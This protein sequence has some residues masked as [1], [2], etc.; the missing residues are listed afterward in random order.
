MGGQQSVP[1]EEQ[2]FNM[3]FTARQLNKLSQKHEKDAAKERKKIKAAIDKGNK[4]GAQIY[5]ENTIRKKN[6]ALQMLQLSSRI[7]GV[8]SK[9]K[10]IQAQ[11]GVARSMGAISQQ[12][13]VA[14]Q[15]M[16]TMAIAQNMDEFERQ[17]N[18][19]D[20]QG[21]MINATMA[22]GAT[23]TPVDEV[24][25]LISQVADEASINLAE[26]FP[27]MASGVAGGAAAEPAAA[28]ATQEDELQRR[29]E[30]LK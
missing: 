15:S 17:L 18:E 28:A 19:L 26:K 23:S 9:L 16:D 2:I 24:D 6:E 3:Q 1:I 21:T 4:E 27:E 14:M 12:L 7:D 10:S 22:M 30:A 25:T 20:M 13:G 29:L 11:R 5:A 8:A